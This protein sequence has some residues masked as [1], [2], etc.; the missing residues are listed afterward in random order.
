[1][2]GT[3]RRA[4]PTGGEPR[5]LLIARTPKGSAMTAPSA[6]RLEILDGP[7]ALATL[8]QPGSRANTLGQAV[9]GDLEGLL[10]ALRGR[11]D[12]VGLVFQSGKPG[13]FIAGA[14][15][16]ELGGARPD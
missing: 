2:S 3:P 6:A 9:L 14:D 12:L 16:K 11:G 1:R 15:L 13:M 10:A 7:V 8:D 5:T 4:F